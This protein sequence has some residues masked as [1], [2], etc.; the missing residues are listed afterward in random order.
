MSLNPIWA[1]F[2]CTDISGTWL[3][4][5]GNMPFPFYSVGLLCFLQTHSPAVLSRSVQDIPLCLLSLLL[6]RCSQQVVASRRGQLTPWGQAALLPVLLHAPLG[7]QGAVTVPLRQHSKCTPA[8]SGTPQPH[9]DG[10]AQ[11]PVIYGAT[12]G[13]SPLLSRPARVL[14][15]QMWLLDNPCS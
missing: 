11:K 8:A 2:S 15:R 9:D 14:E 1:G 13:P 3:Y 10:C 6:G 12:P 5:H 4:L 7:R